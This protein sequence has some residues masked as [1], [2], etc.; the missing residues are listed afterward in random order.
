MALSIR[1]GAGRARL[2]RRPRLLL[3][4]AIA[5]I[6]IVAFFFLFAG[7]FTDYLWY[8]SVDY[9]SVFSGVIVTQILLFVVGALLMVGIVG[10]NT[11]LAYRMP[12]ILTPERFSGGVSGADRYR[13]ALDPHRKLIFLIGVAVLALFAGSSFAGQWKTWLEFF[14][15]VPFGELDA[16]F[17]TDISFFMF[18]LPFIRMVLNFLF[19]AV[20][21]SAVMATIVHYLYGG[22]ASSRR[23]CAPRARPGCT[24]RCCSACSCCSRPSPTGSTGTTSS[25]PS[26]A[27][28]TGPPTPTST[29]CCPPRPSWRSS[30]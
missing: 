14:N 6:A 1:P 11:L 17:K 3:P 8:D 19:T 21:L 2:P 26:G 16:Q 15:A 25:S 29:R 9:T 30:R 7:I 20:V 13:M 28:C 23:A 24:C 18:T 22:S 10:G 27:S 4:V 12:P 5:L